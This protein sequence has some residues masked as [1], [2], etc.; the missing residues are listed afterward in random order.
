M[1]PRG[2]KVGRG[3]GFFPGQEVRWRVRH[4][5]LKV[6][7]LGS[8]VGVPRAD[9]EVLGQRLGGERLEC[10]RPVPRVVSGSGGYRA[11]Y[12]EVTF[13]PTFFSQGERGIKGACGLDGEKGDKVQR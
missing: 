4:L 5:G 1:G 8:D 6:S 11:G 3:L 13:P 12:P 7:C 9:C 10:L 2:L